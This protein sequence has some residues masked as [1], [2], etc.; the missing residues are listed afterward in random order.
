MKHI[1]LSL[2]VMAGLP[3]VAL[4]ADLPQRNIAPEYSEPQSTPE[5]VW[6]GLYVGGQLGGAFGHESSVTSIPPFAPIGF[7]GVATPATTDPSGFI[8]GAHIGYNFLALPM[9]SGAVGIVGLEGDIDGS[10]YRRVVTFG[11]GN[12]FGVGVG[13]AE[14]VSS[15]IQGSVRARLG[16]AVNRVLFYGIGG[17]TIGQFDTSYN[18]VGTGY[19][20]FSH[21]LTGYVFGA[22]AEYAITP[23]WAV[24]VEYLYSQFPTFY[25]HTIHASAL[26]N[27]VV[28][29]HEIEQRL[30][31]GISYKFD[32]PVIAKY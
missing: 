17:V 2:A 27:T 19:D 3:A 29:Q 14:T 22:G 13:S 25:D 31:V 15:N 6:T 7:P 16:V 26:P 30:E 5:T 8:G 1:I 24:R 32:T 21:V 12:P 28:S 4:A 23:N 18:N 9:L 11:P 20:S 10:T